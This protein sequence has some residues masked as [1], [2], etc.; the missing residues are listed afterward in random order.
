[1]SSQKELVETL[2]KYLVEEPDSVNVTETT[3]R[4]TKLYNVTVAPNDVGRV[5][6]KDGRVITCVRHFVAAAGSKNRQKTVVKV[7]TQD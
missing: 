1:M 2:I 4:G 5:I 6:G 3:D 7:V